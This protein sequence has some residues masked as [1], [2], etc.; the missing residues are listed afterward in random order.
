[1]R[2]FPHITYYLI[3]LGVLLF[4]VVALVS[5]ASHNISIITYI[6][7][8]FS[9]VTLIVGNIAIGLFTYSLLKK[10]RALFKQSNQMLKMG[11]VVFSLSSCLNTLFSG[12]QASKPDYNSSKANFCLR[13]LILLPGL[14]KFA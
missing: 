4:S 9:V 5:D 3:G 10:S 14:R 13:L 11:N 6:N 12:C 2:R 8:A 7:P 1:M